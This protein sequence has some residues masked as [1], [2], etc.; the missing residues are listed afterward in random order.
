MW[1]LIGAI[2]ALAV[3][4][5]AWQ[6]SRSP[7]AT[8]YERDVYDMTPAVHRRYA[9]ASL[10]FAILFIVGAAWPRVPAVP[11]L[12]VYAVVAILYLA[13]FVRG[14]TGEDE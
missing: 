3:S 7:K 1:S 13:S 14:A 12:A 6:R 2:L 10:A 11:L 5:F 9:V 8:F 4:G